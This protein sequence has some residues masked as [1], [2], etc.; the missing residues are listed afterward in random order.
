MKACREKIWPER[1]IEE[2]L[3][4]LRREVLWLVEQTQDQQQA[5]GRLLQ[6]QH[7]ENGAVVV[8]M[9]ENFPSYP[10]GYHYKPTALA[11]KG[12]AAIA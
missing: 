4:A 11:G 8:P 6:H 1:G 5:I 2:K 9:T 3:E 7:G 12:S 10:P